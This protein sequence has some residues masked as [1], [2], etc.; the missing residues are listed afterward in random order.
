MLTL[1]LQTA[2]GTS[3]GGAPVPR[4]QATVWL[5]EGSLQG[6]GEE[7]GPGAGAV[8]AVEPVDGATKID[9]TAGE[10]RLMGA[11]KGGNTARSDKTRGICA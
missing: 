5:C 9:A 2:A 10:L 1:R 8:R 11:E 6:A 7:Y 3:E 4:D